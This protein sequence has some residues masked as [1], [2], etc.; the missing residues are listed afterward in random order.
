MAKKKEVGDMTRINGIPEDEQI[1]LSP[2]K[3]KLF[4]DSPRLFWDV[5][6]GNVKLPSTPFPQLP[7]GF[8]REIKKY[9]DSYRE[10]GGMPEQLS[11]VM[12][13]K[14]YKLYPDTEQL[15]RWRNWRTG[16]VY[17]DSDLNAKVVGALDDLMVS[18]DGIYCPYDYKTKG[19]KPKEGAGE[20]YQHQLDFY[21]LLLEANGMPT[22]GRAFLSFFWPID[23]VCPLTVEWPATNSFIFEINHEIMPMKC[24]AGRAERVFAQAV[25][26]LRGNRPENDMG[27]D[28]LR[29]IEDYALLNEAYT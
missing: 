17:E 15:N 18:D 23:I 11:S 19:S 5:N 7:N 12:G 25:E 26:C 3:V 8:D 10:K 2:S 22:D 14:A 24:D 28:H 27:D 13:E 6:V 29:F 20:F 21:A 4:L 9:M 16:L 1:R